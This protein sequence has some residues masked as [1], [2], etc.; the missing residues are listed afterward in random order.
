MRDFK[1]GLPLFTPFEGPRSPYPVAVFRIVFFGALALHFFPSL[2]RLEEFYGPGVLR[3]EEWNRWLYLHFDRI[4][5]GAL[6]AGAMATMAACVMGMIGLAPRLAALITFIGL[7][8]FASFNG[9]PVQTLALVEAWAILLL[10]IICGGG[11]AVWSLDAVIRRK[12]GAQP[13]SVAPLKAP[14]AKRQESRTAAAE[15]SREGRLLASLILYQILLAVFFSG[16]EKVIAGWPWTNEMGVVLSYPKGFMV[17]D[18]VRWMDWLRWPVVTGFLSLLTV[19]VE[20]AAPVL[21]LFRRTRIPA[22]IVYEVFFLGIIAM[23][24]VP[25]LFYFIFAAGAF[26]ALDDA[27]VEELSA[28]LRALVPGGSRPPHAVIFPRGR[29]DR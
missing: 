7:Y 5:P 26:L 9:L 15:E 12:T 20:L 17:R 28:R 25:P 2:I 21:L 24:E 14:K 19:L 8:A 22:L 11:S 23:L 18:W 1:I 13:E 10:W 6:R 29:R 16:I 27:Q 4:P 3:S